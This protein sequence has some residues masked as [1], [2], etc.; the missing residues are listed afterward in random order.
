MGIFTEGITVECPPGGT[1]V[2]L[3][4]RGECWSVCDEPLCWY[5]RRPWWERETRM[6][7]GEG[8]GM[9]DTRIW[10][11]QVRKEDPHGLSDDGGGL[12]LDVVQQ[13]PGGS[14]RVIKI[15][16]AVDDVFKEQDSA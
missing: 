2:R 8:V 10:R 16:D 15:H 5:E 7:P 1:P 3:S 13:R 4:W 14:W 11:L 6:P 12:T 9:V